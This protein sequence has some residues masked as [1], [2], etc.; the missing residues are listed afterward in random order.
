[1]PLGSYVLDYF[2]SISQYLAVGPPV[3]F[4]VTT[5]HNYTSWIGGQRSVCSFSGCANTSLPNV[6]AAYAKS[7]NL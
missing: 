3:Y 6:I 4:V 5:G 1:M 2:D 7:S